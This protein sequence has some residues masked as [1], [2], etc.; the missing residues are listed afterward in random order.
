MLLKARSDFNDLK[1]ENDVLSSNFVNLQRSL[2]IFETQ[3]LNS[4]SKKQEKI[5]ALELKHKELE[6]E[7]EVLTG[8][9]KDNPTIDECN[10]QIVDL[11]DNKLNVLKSCL[12]AFKKTK[13]GQEATGSTGMTPDQEYFLSFA[14]GWL[15]QRRPENLAKQIMT[16]VHSPSMY[17]VNGPASNIESFYK[18]FGVRPGDPM[19][20]SE[21]KRVTIW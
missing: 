4:E 19:H 20:R 16:D 6:K 10:K 2:S 17:R 12:K 21:E 18:A 1:K 14:Y 9:N 7:R 8:N 3:K 5:V 15:V 13:A 11:E